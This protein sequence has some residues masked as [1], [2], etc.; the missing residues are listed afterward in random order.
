M[1]ANIAATSMSDLEDADGETIAEALAL[2]ERAREYAGDDWHARVRLAIN[3]SDAMIKLGRYEE[4]IAQA[5]DA[6][7]EARRRGE[8]GSVG[9]ILASNVIEPL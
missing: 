7:D 2:Y 4:A 8:E 3:R 5:Q 6:L 9:P 1:G